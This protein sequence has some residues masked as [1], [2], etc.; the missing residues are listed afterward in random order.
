VITER[1]GIGEKLGQFVP[2]ELSFVND[3]G[4]PVTLRDLVRTPTVIGLQYYTCRNACGVLAVAMADVLGRLDSLPGRDYL[5]LSNSINPAKVR[6][7]P[8]TLNV[9]PSNPSA[10]R[11]RRGP[12]V[13]HRDHLLDRREGPGGGRMVW[14]LRCSRQYIEGTQQRGYARKCE[15]ENP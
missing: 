4:T 10:R 6:R 14:P 7:M 1:I 9:S 8:G 13:F 2:L 11:T 3:D 12:G 15:R 5:V